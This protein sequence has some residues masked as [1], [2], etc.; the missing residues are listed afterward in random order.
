MKFFYDTEFDDNGRTIDIISIGML[1][2]SGAEFYA[3]SDEFSPG[4][5]NAWVKENVLPF[6]AHNAQIPWMFRSQIACELREFVE[7][8]NGTEKRAEFWGWYSAYDHVVMAQ[9]YGPMVNLPKSFPMYT[10]DIKQ[11]CDRHGNPKLPPQDGQ[12]HNALYDAYWNK[13]AYDFMIDH[14]RS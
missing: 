3:V 7:K 2:E 8:H 13:K 6:L 12:E 14:I 11:M 4:Q 9:L 5:C 1:A 10:C